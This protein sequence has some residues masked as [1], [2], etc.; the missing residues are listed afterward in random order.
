VSSQCL[1]DLVAA[2]EARLGCHPRRR[3]E[4]LQER[5]AAHQ[6]QLARQDADL[7][8]LTMAQHAAR[9]RQAALHTALQQARRRVLRLTDYPVSPTQAGPGGALTQ[10][11]R[12]V[13]GLERQAA[14]TR[15]LLDQLQQEVRRGWQTRQAMQAV[16]APLLARHAQLSAENAAYPGAPPMRLRM[17]AGFCNGE[18]LTAVLELGYEVETKA[19]HPSM[20]RA[21][22][23]GSRRT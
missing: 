3:V 23:A 12:R 14:H 9:Q 19:A 13:R 6:V 16:L 7:A 22:L 20:V 2:A 8:A 4:L 17:D 11:Q 10:A 18:T 15:T 1:L 5:L 21:L